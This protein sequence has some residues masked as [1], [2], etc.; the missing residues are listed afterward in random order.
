MEN[1][2]TMTAIIKIF[3][4]CYPFALSRPLVTPDAN[5]FNGILSGYVLK[6]EAVA[7]FSSICA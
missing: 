1:A 3:F 4:T 7:E 5:H 2:A 6:L